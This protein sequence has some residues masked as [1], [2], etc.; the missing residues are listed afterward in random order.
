METLKP[1]LEKDLFEYQDELPVIVQA[2]L[3]RY[4]DLEFEKGL[5]YNDLKQMAKEL[6][7]YGYEFEFYLDCVPYNLKKITKKTNSMN[8]DQY[9]FSQLL[10]LFDFDYAEMPYNEQYEEALSRYEKFDNSEFNSDKF[11]LYECI[12]NYLK[13]QY[14]K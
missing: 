7:I 11:G 3:K 10:A 8:Y 6:A 2:V 5:Q 12:V 14:K 13:N 1:F 9:L 4:N